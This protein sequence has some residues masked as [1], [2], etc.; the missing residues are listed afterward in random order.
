MDEV[1]DGWSTVLVVSVLEI[2]VPV[3]AEMTDESLAVDNSVDSRAL[4]RDVLIIGESTAEVSASIAVGEPAACVMIGSSVALVNSSD[5]PAL[6][7]VDASDAVIFARSAL[8]VVSTP[9]SVF[10]ALAESVGESPT[11]V[12]S[13]DCVDVASD[14]VI[15]DS[16]TELVVSVDDC[17]VAADVLNT[18]TSNATPSLVEPSAVPRDAVI[19]A[20]STEDVVDTEASDVEI[21]VVMLGESVALLVS[22]ADNGP[23]IAL[24][25]IELSVTSTTSV[26]ASGPAEDVV[27][28][29]V[30]TELADSVDV[31]N[32]LEVV[33][34]V[35]ES[36][37]SASSV[38]AN[39]DEID[40]VIEDASDAVD[41]DTDESTSPSDCVITDTSTVEDVSTAVSESDVD[42]VISDVLTAIDVLDAEIDVDKDGETV[43]ASTEVLAESPVRGDAIDA[44]IIAA[45]TE[46]VVSSEVPTLVPVDA[47]DATIV[48]VSVVLDVSVPVTL[49]PAVAERLESSPTVE[50]SSLCSALERDD[51]ITPVSAEVLESVDNSADESDEMIVGE[52]TEL[53]VSSLEIVVAND[54]DITD[55]SVD[56]DICVDVRGEPIESTNVAES[57]D[58]DSESAEN[59]D[60]LDDVTVEPSDAIAVSELVSVAVVLPDSVEVSVSDAGPI[61][62]LLRTALLSSDIYRYCCTELQSVQ[63]L[64]FKKSDVSRP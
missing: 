24:V 25:I 43:D 15:T 33:V 9:I 26:D 46:I 23:A 50:S 60:E 41:D 8:P 2:A 38:E 56:A 1:I 19:A 36:T 7:P 30:S 11:N 35:G 14:T 29:D 57:T 58:E 44:A 12:N 62:P 18:D 22:V 3:D 31:S 55:V 20:A 49:V 28:T 48:A 32:P 54:G 6:V 53:A 47:S 16:S 51:V 17:V 10:P 13:S 61:T 64:C 59:G 63:Q 39:R 45:S 5:V 27:M 40:S 4:D 21:D 42:A 34:I 37:A 52:S